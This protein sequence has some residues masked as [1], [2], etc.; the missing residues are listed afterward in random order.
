MRSAKIAAVFAAVSLGALT[1]TG[2]ARAQDKV[3]VGT[4]ANPEIVALAVG[5]EEGFFK[6]RG[7]NVQIQI[8]SLNPTI[9]PA[10]VAGSLQIGVPTPNLFAQAVENGLD[11][12][13]IAGVTTIT[14]DLRTVAIVARDAANIKT[15]KD[16]EGKKIAVP[17]INAV[18][19][20]SLQVWLANGGA[21]PN[22]V[23]WVESPLANMGDIL[24]AGQ[25][26]AVIGV[27]PFLTR[28]VNAGT[29]KVFSYF[30]PEVGEGQQTMVYATTREW[31]QKNP[32]IVKAFR[33][34]LEESIAF[35]KTD[36]DK[37]REHMGKYF[38]VPPEVLKTLP[39]PNSAPKLQ[40]SQ[41]T[42]W[43][44]VMRKVGLMQKPLDAQ[45]VLWP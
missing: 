17:G 26:D 34:G 21:D 35:T 14:K 15:I 41:L 36:P 4:S 32:Q 11:L 27:D 40:A 10:L 7:A 13:A 37:S 44:D 38:K 29:G 45:K 39:I 23:Q 9:P 19:H 31:A 43:A 6:K 30:L 12:V 33:E 24:K 28:L 20:I 42:F 2:P 3:I 16:F 22:K 5:V 25:V 8:V 18:L 1:L